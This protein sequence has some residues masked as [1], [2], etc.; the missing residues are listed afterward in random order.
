MQK[1]THYSNIDDNVKK[2][3]FLEIQTL[4]LVSF[5]S[6]ATLSCPDRHWRWAPSKEEGFISAHSSGESSP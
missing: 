3:K 4:K 2:K 5:Y 6:F 1:Q